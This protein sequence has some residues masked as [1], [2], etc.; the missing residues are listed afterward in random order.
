[1]KPF[2][3]FV[4]LVLTALLPGKAGGAEPEAGV[5]THYTSSRRFNVTYTARDKGSGVAKVEMFLSA[6]GGRTWRSAG[7]DEDKKSPF[8][9]EV[10]ADGTYGFYPVAEDNVGNRQKP[11][12][13]GTR[14]A[15]IVVVDTVRPVIENAGWVGRGALP[16]GGRIV[17]TWNVTDANAGEAPV[18]IEYSTNGGVRWESG[19]GGRGFPVAGEA[20]FRAPEARSAGLRLRLVAVDLSGNRTVK[21]IKMAVRVDRDRPIVKLLS[22]AAGGVYAG[23]A[24]IRIRWTAEDADLAAKP[25]TV[26]VSLDDGVTWEAVGRDL[27]DD[28]EGITWRTPAR[29]LASVKVRVTAT[30]QMGN[31]SVDVLTGGFRVDAPPPESTVG[32]LPLPAEGGPPIRA[33]LA[34]EEPETSPEPEDAEI[35]AAE[36][37]LAAGRA[38]EARRLAS[39]ILERDAKNVRALLVRGRAYAVEGDLSGSIRVLERAIELDARLETDVRLR[40]EIGRF[41]CRAG[42]GLVRRAG[43]LEKDA[44]GRPGMLREAGNLFR[45]AVAH[46]TAVLRA[47]G[48]GGAKDS[49]RSAYCNRGLARYYLGELDGGAGRDALWN[50]AIEDLSAS[51]GGARGNPETLGACHWYTAKILEAR[52]RYAEACVAWIK[53]ARAYGAESERGRAATEQAERLRGLR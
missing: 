34:E 3:L 20:T 23:D 46:Y 15:V 33:A 24:E 8:P 25:I 43:A 26:E 2:L 5:E 29:D 14:P 9:F 50:A 36:K 44:P 10:Q 17:V 16:P 51:A 38:E 19:M 13:P 4:P 39:R 45:R 21:E 1:M 31:Q 37:A 32:F 6:D 30:D 28:P 22:P 11:P 27:A 35:A 41:C 42:Q 47:C 12:E 40:A 18:S 49:L 52:K 53:A 7:F 48:T